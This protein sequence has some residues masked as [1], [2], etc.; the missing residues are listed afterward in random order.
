[1]KDKDFLTEN[2]VIQWVENFLRQKG[3]T[4][5]RRVVH[6]ADAAIKESGVDLIVKL[7]NEKKNGNW[8]FIEA[9]GNLKADGSRMKSSYNTN[10][11]WLLS[12]IILRIKVDSRRNNHIFGIAMPRSDI[13][14]CRKMIR[15]NWALKHLKIRLYG[16]FYQDDQLT[17]IEY[18]PKDLYK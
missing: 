12:E 9:R 3:R 10:F 13:E 11:R 17:A 8:H 4:T 18:L 14:L 7:E 6:K 16:A 15:D 1:M 2:E 5:H